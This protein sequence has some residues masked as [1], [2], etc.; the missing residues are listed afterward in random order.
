MIGSFQVSNVEK[1]KFYEAK[2]I[3]RNSVDYSAKTIEIAKERIKQYRIK[4]PIK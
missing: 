4:N 1:F 2:S 3:V